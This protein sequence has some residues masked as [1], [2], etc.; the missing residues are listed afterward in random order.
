MRSTYI[1]LDEFDERYL[2]NLVLS[3][4]RKDPP[5]LPTLDLIYEQAMSNVNFPRMS[6]STLWR[7]LR[8]LGF[9]CKKRNKKLQVYQRLDVVAMRHRYLRDIEHF[10]ALGYKCFFQDESY[11]NANHTREYIWQLDDGSVKD[12]FIGHIRWTGGLKVPSGAGKRLIINHIG[13]KDGFLQ[14][15]E[16]VFEGKKGT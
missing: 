12:S 4:Y 3:S 8:R 9:V 16:E 15:C 2:S 11:C 14:N 7:R 10:R 6:K 13:S 5:Q 1:S